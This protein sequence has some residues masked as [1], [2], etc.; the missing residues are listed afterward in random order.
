MTVKDPD[1]YTMLDPSS[2]EL[3]WLLNKNKMKKFG[4]SSSLMHR[5][6]FFHFDAVPIR[7]FYPRFYIC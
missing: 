1:S 6:P 3:K 7:G 5:H 4:V 2:G